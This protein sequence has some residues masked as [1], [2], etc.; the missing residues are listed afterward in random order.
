MGVINYFSEQRFCRTTLSNEELYVFLVFGIQENSNDDGSDHHLGD[1]YWI[2]NVWEYVLYKKRENTT[3]D[4]IY[5]K[6]MSSLVYGCE[7]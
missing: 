5:D 7:V 1:V 2:S 6:T 3:V 4:G